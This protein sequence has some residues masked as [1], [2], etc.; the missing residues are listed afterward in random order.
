MRRVAAVQFTVP[1]PVFGTGNRFEHFEAPHWLIDID[2]KD[3]VLERLASQNIPALPAFRII[4]AAFAV[5]EE[6]HAVAE[7]I[8]VPGPGSRV[9]GPAPTQPAGLGGAAAN[10][11]AADPKQAQG[12]K[13]KAPKVKP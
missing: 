7:R 13:A 5:P 11:G 6:K 3:V 12:R 2:G 9:I 10:A 4:G 1:V 8:D